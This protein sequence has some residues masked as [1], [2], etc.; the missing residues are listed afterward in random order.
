SERRARG[1]RAGTV[2]RWRQGVVRARFHPWRRPDSRGYPVAARRRRRAAGSEIVNVGEGLSPTRRGGPG[3]D[4]ARR[5]CPAAA[6]LPYPRYYADFE[7]TQ[8]AVPV[9]KDTRPYEQLPFQ[10]SCHV[11]RADGSIEQ[12]GFLDLS[13]QP[14]MRAFLE[15]LIACL[16]TTGPVFSYSS[17]ER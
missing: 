9:W 4:A 1:D 7:T 2:H 10:W 11:E 15:S 6:I 8:M 17:F 12:R 5:W 16:S 13:G 3:V 14:P